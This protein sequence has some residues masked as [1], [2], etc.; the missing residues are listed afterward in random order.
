MQNNVYSTFDL[1]KSL[2]NFP[3][4]V[5]KVLE[6]TKISEFD[7]RIFK[8]HEEEIRESALVLAGECIALLLHNLSKSQEFLDKAV[9][10]T[11]GWWQNN[12]QK[13]GNKR[14]QILT[15]GNVE[16]KSEIAICS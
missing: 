5:T 10:Q 16:V 7:G 6:S 2:S 11:Q 13:H 9:E 15:V 4:K 3:E 8:L 12:K 1:S 14:R